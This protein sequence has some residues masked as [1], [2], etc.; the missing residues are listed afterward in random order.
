MYGNRMHQE[1]DRIAT[2][3]WKAQKGKRKVEVILLYGDAGTGKTTIAF[4]KE[5]VFGRM[6]SDKPWDIYRGEKVVCF[7]DY[8]GQIKLGEFLR[9]IDIFPVTVRVMYLGEKPWIPETIYICSN[10]PWEAWYP[11]AT[12]EQKQAI[13]RRLHKIIRFDKRRA[14]TG[15]DVVIQTQ[16][17]PVPN[18]ATNPA[19]PAA[20]TRTWTSGWNSQDYL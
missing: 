15:D 10:L 3:D 7:D 12:K 6:D 18:P 13:E 16:E 14:I 9:L 1:K 8:T 5:A 19:A 17:K 11:H 20:V 4:E 2:K